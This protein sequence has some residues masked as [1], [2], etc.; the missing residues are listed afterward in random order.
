MNICA[1]KERPILFSTPMVRAILDGRETQTRRAFSKRLLKL[2]ANTA[3]CGEV[4]NFLDEEILG[5]HDHEYIVQFCSYGKPGDRLWVRETFQPL[6]AD[7]VENHSETN[8]RTGEGYT[9][10]YPATDGIQEFIDADDNISD[11]CMPSI[12]MPRW[13][14]RILLEVANVRVERLLDISEEDAISEGVTFVLYRSFAP[15]D[16]NL[17]SAA[18][19]ELAG[20]NLACWCPT[21]HEMY[22]EDECHAAVLLKIANEG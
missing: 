21:P 18:R 22:Q 7:G 5:K 9:V 20:K 1:T 17:V 3:S 16:E 2:M 14:S 4:S 12:H 8:W 11:A 15:L 10:S 13:A 19:K 6:F